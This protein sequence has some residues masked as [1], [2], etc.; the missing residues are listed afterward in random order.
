MTTQTSLEEYFIND[1]DEL[2]NMM[3]ESSLSVRMDDVINHY[4]TICNHQVSH[5]FIRDIQKQHNDW[6]DILDHWELE[7]PEHINIHTLL[8]NSSYSHLDI[9]CAQV[10]IMNALE[11]ILRMHDLNYYDHDQL[12]AYLATEL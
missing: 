3:Q 12:R 9:A 8:R 7:D 11:A 6:A 5:Q 10:S 2:T 4:I 1:I